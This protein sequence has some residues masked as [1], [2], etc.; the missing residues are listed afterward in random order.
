M[1]LEATRAINVVCFQM[2]CSSNQM[3]M[4]LAPVPPTPHLISLP[5]LTCQDRYDIY[6]TEVKIAE[7]RP[8]QVRV[9]Y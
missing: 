8:A 4:G 5:K 6:C 2:P 7:C 9:R 3:N 1:R